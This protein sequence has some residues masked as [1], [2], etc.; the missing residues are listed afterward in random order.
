MNMTERLTTESGGIKIKLSLF[1]Q[2][3]LNLLLPYF[4]IILE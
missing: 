4:K 1:K 3:F 2:T